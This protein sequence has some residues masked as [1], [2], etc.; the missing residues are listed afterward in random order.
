MMLL[1]EKSKD[2]QSKDYLVWDPWMSVSKSVGFIIQESWMSVQIF[3]LDQSD[4][5]TFPPSLAAT[6]PQK[7]MITL[8]PCAIYQLF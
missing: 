8:H 6:M 3:S 7:V 2:H 4:G 5:P 1:D